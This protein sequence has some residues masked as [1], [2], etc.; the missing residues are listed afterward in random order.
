MLNSTQPTAGKRR[1]SRAPRRLSPPASCATSW[2][3]SACSTASMEAALRPRPRP[4][5]T[6]LFFFFPL[7]VFSPMSFSWFMVG[8]A[9]LN[10]TQPTAGKRRASRAPRRLSPPASCATSIAA[11]ALPA[12]RRV[13]VAVVTPVNAVSTCFCSARVLGTSER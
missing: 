6:D 2:A 9:M 10:S 5:A 3:A 1:A 7:V 12:A 11:L 8:P 4:T 13:A